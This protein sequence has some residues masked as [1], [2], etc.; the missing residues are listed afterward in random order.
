MGCPPVPLQM[1]VC[2]TVH[3]IPWSHTTVGHSMGCPHVPLT[4]TPTVHSIPR[5]HESIVTMNTYSQARAR[6]AIRVRLAARQRR[7]DTL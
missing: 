7:D 2:P 4:D 5:S 1:H 3:P 6:G